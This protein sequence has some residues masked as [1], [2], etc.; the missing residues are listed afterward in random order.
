MFG[1]VFGNTIYSA[2]LVVAVFMLGLGVG[3]YIA[4]AWADRRYA[5]RP[6]SLLRAYGYFE[7]VI[8]VM[9]LGI[10][11]LLPHLDQRLGAA[12]SSY[13]REASGWYVLSTTS[14]LARAAIAVVLLTPITLLMGGTLTL[15]IRH[16]VGS[17]LE[18]GGWRIAV[19]YAVN[20]AGAALGCFLTDFA[21]V[22]AAGLL[23]T[24]MVAVFFNVVAALGALYSVVADL[25]E[26][27]ATGQRSSVQRSRPI[28]KQSSWDGPA[29]ASRSERARRRLDKPRA[30]DDRFRG[31]GD[32]D[33]VV[34]AFLDAAGRIPRRV[35]IAA[36]GDPDRDRRGI[37][38]LGGIIY[39]RAFR[40]SAV[41]A[42]RAG[43]VRRFDAVSDLRSPMPEVSNATVSP[44]SHSGRL[45]A[46]PSMRRGAGSP[47][48]C[49]RSTE[50]WF[51][52]RPILLEVAVPAL[53]MGFSFPLANADHPARGTS[54]GR[55][56]GLLYLSNTVG[57]VCG[58]LAC[59]L[60]APADVRHSGQRH[61]ADHRCR[62]GSGA[63]VLPQRPRNPF[64]RGRRSRRL[65]PGRGASV[66]ATVRRSALWL[67]LPSDY[68][69]HPGAGVSGRRRAADHA[70]RRPH[71]G[72]RRD[73]SSRQRDARC[74][75][76]GIRCRR[77]A[78]LSQRY[79]RAL[80]HI[81]LLSIDSPETVLVIGFGVGNTTH[82]ATLH[83][84]IRRVEVADLSRDILAHAG[85]FKR[86]Q[87]GRA[88]R[89][90]GR[91]VCQRRAAPPADAAAGLVQT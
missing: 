36:D 78:R 76:T 57:A 81:P 53:L 59:R 5:T 43:A 16:L 64:T 71:R 67:L 42:G 82:A 1:N 46:A 89:P 44:I 62:A 12:V 83:P 7:L 86:R 79:M 65:A 55:R 26:T 54:V 85:Y 27:S 69:N 60:P 37:A 10:S 50:L 9:G 25:Q 6:E 84:S 88:E 30:R 19:L 22:P 18:A 3:S 24:Q 48:A 13:T 31:D 80:A 8:A 68:V 38:L 72:H 15:L 34:P 70:E 33:R 87:S 49:G 45:P 51:N 39:R 29:A 32:G 2:S 4:G 73:R 40:P 14:Y 17:D 56:A 11:A 63:A 23:G 58:A 52:A 28:R 90:A 35:R 47:A 77:R 74:S 41:V 91:R 20:T 61:R 75:P 21:L 66:I